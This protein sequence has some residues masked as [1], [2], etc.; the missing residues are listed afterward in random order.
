[1][2][3]YSVYKT[4]VDGHVRKAQSHKGTFCKFIYHHQHR[5]Q[6]PSLLLWQL[7]IETLKGDLNSEMAD[8]IFEP[9]DKSQ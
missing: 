3:G 5:L 4:A 1:M 2:D 9:H 6:T 8:F 7:C